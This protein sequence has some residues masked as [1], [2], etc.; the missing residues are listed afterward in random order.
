MKIKLLNDFRKDESGG[1]LAFTLTMFMVMVVGG[2]MAVDFV[3]QETRREGVQDALD[4]GVLAAAAFEQT[5]DPKDIVF[6][7]MRS[8]GYDPVELNVQVVPTIYLNSRR[9]DASADFSVDTFF[10]RL[11]GIEVLGGAAAAGAMIA[12]NEIEISLVVDISGSMRGTKIQNLRDAASEFVSLVLTED[13]VETTTVSLIPFSGQVAANRNLMDQFNLT[14]WQNF[15]SCV[16]FT[17][18]DY[19]TTSLSTTAPLAQAQHWAPQWIFDRDSEWCPRDDIDIVA[20]S[21]DT[22][23]LNAAIDNLRATGMTAANIGMKWGTALLDPA[24]QPV[25]AELINLGDVDPIFAGRPAAYSAE[26]A[27]KFIVLMTDGENTTNYQMREDAY[28]EIEFDE[29][30][31]PV[32]ELSQANAEYWNENRTPWAWSHME[33]RVTAE[34]EDTRL[35]NICDAAKD[36]GIVVFTIGYD[37]GAESNAATQMRDCASSLAHFYN[38]ETA[39]LTTAFQ[40]IA[41]TIQKLKLVN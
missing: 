40:S 31:V 14:R 38:V 32:P 33:V 34:Q 25:V 23:E 36:A 26:D 7:Y 5:L 3:N 4:R 28:G 41:Q 35:Q 2:G 39:D 21:N 1:I 16:N 19:N 29:N 18:I 10:L 8:S 37:V 11:A 27:L 22:V 9:I 15:S 20:F 30:G 12:R 13:T 6:A 17:A 24:A